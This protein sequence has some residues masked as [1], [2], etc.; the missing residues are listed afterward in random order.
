MEKIYTRSYAAMTAVDRK[1]SI[2]LSKHRMRGWKFKDYKKAIARIK[3]R[4]AAGDGKLNENDQTRKV[5]ELMIEWQAIREL[6]EEKLV[7]INKSQ[8]SD[9]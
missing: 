7:C 6:L 5:S 4:L 3:E 1:R 8:S 2:V 9:E